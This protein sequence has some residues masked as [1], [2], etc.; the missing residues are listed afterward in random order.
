MVAMR[1]EDQLERA[2]DDG[3]D[4]RWGRQAVQTGTGMLVFQALS[5]L[6]GILLAR[7]LGADRV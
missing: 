2:F 4:Y 5:L 6:A 3:R 7:G 1:S